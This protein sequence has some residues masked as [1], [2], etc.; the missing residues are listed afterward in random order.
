MHVEP[1]ALQE[2]ALNVP[3]I[4][5]VSPTGRLREG[6]AP[7]RT[8][9]PTLQAAHALEHGGGGGGGAERQPRLQQEQFLNSSGGGR[10]RP[11]SRS[12]WPYE[13]KCSAEKAETHAHIGMPQP[14]ALFCL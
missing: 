3:I 6:L 13:R 12:L 1:H 4:T 14:R 5:A 2:H 9:P 8:A 7:S 10:G 11:E